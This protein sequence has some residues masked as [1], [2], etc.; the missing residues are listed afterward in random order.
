[1][2]RRRRRVRGRRPGRWPARARCHPRRAR[3]RSRR[4]GSV[5][6]RGGETRVG[7]RGPWSP[8]QSEGAGCV[9]DRDLDGRSRRRIAD[10][11][12]EQIVDS[13]AQVVAVDVA[14]MSRGASSTTSTRRGV[15]WTRAAS[16]AR[17]RI[18]WSGW[19]SRVRVATT[20]SCRARNSSSSVRCDRRSV[21]A[22][23]CAIEAEVVACAAGPSG[24]LELGAEDR[25]RCPQLVAGVGD[26]GAL[27]GEGE[28]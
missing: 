2:P 22:P 3:G 5:R 17:S 12:R 28:L 15:A 27:L 7:S 24:E 11:V 16:T 13:A 21:S 1:M 14:A 25:E 20:S 8:L 19:S 26:E 18:G 9:P 10:G 23:A 6:R 4:A